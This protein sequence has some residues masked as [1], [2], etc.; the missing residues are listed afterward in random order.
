MPGFRHSSIDES[1]LMYI[2]TLIF[3]LQLLQ[4]QDSPTKGWKT[5]LFELL[6]CRFHTPLSSREK[7]TFEPDHDIVGTKTVQE[8]VFIVLFFSL[9]NSLHVGIK[10]SSN[11]KF[12][13]SL[14]R[15][16]GSE[17]CCVATDAGLGSTT[18]AK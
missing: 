9:D 11:S 17:V 18:S 7:E 2:H 1:I 10:R 4:N 5:P 6:L 14:R 15:L 16:Q 3:F 8:K 13:L 12:S